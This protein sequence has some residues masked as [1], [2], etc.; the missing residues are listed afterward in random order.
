VGVPRD[1]GLPPYIVKWLSDGHFAMVYPEQ[2]AMIIW[3]LD[4]ASGE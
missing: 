3:M 1:D 4:P 2:T